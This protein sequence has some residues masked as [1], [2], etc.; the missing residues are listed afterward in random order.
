MFGRFT[1]MAKKEL[2]K[3]LSARQKP[4]SS[5]KKETIIIIAV[6]LILALIDVALVVAV[7]KHYDAHSDDHV[8]ENNV[9]SQKIEYPKYLADGA[10]SEGKYF[11]VSKTGYG[12]DVD[13][14]QVIKQIDEYDYDDFILSNNPTDFVVIRVENY[15]D[16]VLA[17]R[18]DIAPLTVNNFKALVLKDFYDDTVIHRVVKDLMIHGGKASKSGEEK[19]TNAILGE[20]SHNNY[21][22][23][24]K[25][26]K[27]IISMARE[28]DNDTATSQFFIMHGDG[29]KLNG[30]YASFG[31]VLAGLDVVDA[32]AKCSVKASS[33]TG[34]KSVP[35]T[36]IVI[37]DVFF[38]EPKEGTGISTDKKFSEQVQKYEITFVDED[39]KPIQAVPFKLI[40][41][42]TKKESVYAISNEKGKAFF[43]VIKAG[44]YIEIV[45]VNGYSYEE[46]YDIPED[47]TS[48]TI[49]LKKAIEE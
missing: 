16:I 28:T 27:G 2:E 7:V 17:L 29:S 19:T 15:G 21:E 4:R 13:M 31:Y 5:K 39:G 18:E 33:T 49:T 3:K 40:N 25:H 26:F 23:N 37:K 9:Q 45:G 47:K 46:R 48:L 10:K 38:V 24:L 35:I 12:V 34:E 20:F 11:D 8:A 44:Y 32:I 1:V 22:N 42:S 6:V 43:D 41:A 14:E 36:Q 30:S